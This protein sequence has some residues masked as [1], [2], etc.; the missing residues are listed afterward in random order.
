[1]GVYLTTTG[2]SIEQTDRFYGALKDEGVDIRSILGTL[3]DLGCRERAVF[4]EYHYW[5][6]HMK[7]IAGSHKISLGRAYEILYRA[8]RKIKASR[9]QKAQEECGGLS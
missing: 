1:M 9:A 8:E 7:V 3:D 6:T 2:D 4:I 5:N